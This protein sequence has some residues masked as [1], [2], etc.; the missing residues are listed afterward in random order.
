MFTPV[1][2]TPAGI[3][4]AT[5][6][7]GDNFGSATYTDGNEPIATFLDFFILNQDAS[8]ILNQDGSKIIWGE[9]L[10]GF[11]DGNSATA[12]TYIVGNDI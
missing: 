12:T 10:T 2:Y 5:N 11:I 9:A 7:V 8:Y 6:V 4:N 1:T 3:G